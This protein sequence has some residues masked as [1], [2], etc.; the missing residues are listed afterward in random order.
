MG[1]WCRAHNCADK[2]QDTESP[3]NGKILYEA[4][5]Q[6]HFEWHIVPFAS[7][8]RY[9]TT[10]TRHKKLLPKFGSQ[11][12]GAMMVGYKTSCGGSWGKSYLVIEKGDFEKLTETDSARFTRSRAS[13]PLS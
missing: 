5:F 8:T 13:L 7:A 6:K 4:K 3:F 10:S 9:K 11:T 2:I 1:Y 12:L